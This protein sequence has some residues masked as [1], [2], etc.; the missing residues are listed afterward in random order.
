MKNVL[1]PCPELN[2]LSKVR[3][4]DS[5]D[6]IF[7][8]VI[9]NPHI[10]SLHPKERECTEMLCALLRNSIVVRNHLLN[11][12]AGLLGQNID[13]Y[14]GL[15]FNFLTEQA[16]GPN[17]DDLR[18]LGWR[19]TEEN[20]ELAILWTI[21][22]K[23]GS[24]FHYGVSIADEVDD[25]EAEPEL[26]NQLMNYDHWLARQTAVNRGGVVLALHDYSG[27]LPAGL[28]CTWASTSWT[29][30]AESIGQCLQDESPTE[31]DRFIAQ[32]VLGFI[33]EHLWRTEEMQKAGLDFDDIALIRAFTRFGVDVERKINVLV[34]GLAEI[35]ER[36]GL[37]MGPIA[38][39]KS[40]FKASKRSVLY[41]N[42]LDRPVSEYPQLLMGISHSSCSLRLETAP[43]NRHK[44]QVT[45]ALQKILPQ[46]QARMS[47]WHIPD[48]TW[49][50]LA[51]DA[52]LIDLLSAD[53][54]EEKFKAFFESAVN[55]LIAVDVA[56]V[57]RKEIG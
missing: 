34:G 47:K 22:V 56:N 43:T 37:G 41:R 13:H 35:L 57:I 32:H 49:G 55:D 28:E 30:L 39:Q 52:P 6:N 51:L 7:G 17:R 44:S 54:Q 5:E 48:D 19:D 23:V 2:W 1:I 4:P 9:R 36:N 20:T 16:I 18:I 45:L 31:N 11:Y 38:H 14:D 27:S 24:T 42:V 33:R 40:M 12:F 26:V 53:D 25:T 3:L 8:R 29:K 46:L 21:E 50:D 10:T 15:A